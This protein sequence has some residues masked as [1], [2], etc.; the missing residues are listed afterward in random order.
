MTFDEVQSL[1]AHAIGASPL[2]RRL[3]MAVATVEPDR[4]RV[5]LPFDADNTTIGDLIHGGAIAA[6][7]DVTATATAWS[8]TDL[9]ASPQGTTI[10]FSV[11][12]VAGARGC[13]LVAEGRIVRRGRQITVCDV[14]V[15]DPDGG[16]VARALVTYKLSGR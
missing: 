8:T 5:R 12:F 3:G 9:P 15:T 6:L 7:V 1:V 2:A 16:T 4:V 11:S 10:G 14:D 13:D